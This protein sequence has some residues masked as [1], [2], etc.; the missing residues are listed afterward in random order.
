[1]KRLFYLP[2]PECFPDGNIRGQVYRGLLTVLFLILSLTGCGSGGGGGGGGTTTA[3]L[4]SIAVTPANP[5]VTLGTTGQFTATGTY[6]DSS[7]QNITSSV[8]WSSSDTSKA[9]ISVSG[10]ATTVSVGSTTITA[11]SGS[12][13]GSTTLTISPINPPTITLPK[14]GRTTCYDAAGGVISC[15]NTGQDGDL[16][17]G[18]AWPSPRFTVDGTG[19]CVTDNLTGLMWVRTPD[20]TTRTRAT[21][22]T[23][24]NGLTLCGYTDWR[25]PNVK[26]LRSLINH[27][28]TSTA[29]W[30]NTQGFSN[31]QGDV[32]WSSTG[33]DTTALD[34][35]MWSG[36]V[37]SVVFGTSTSYVWPVRAGGGAT[38]DLP[39]TGQT[40]SYATGDDGNL[41]EGAAWPIPRFTVDGTWLCVTDNLTGLMWVKAPDSTTQTWENAL[42]YANNLTLCGYSDW[43]LPNVNELES[44]RNAE[45]NNTATWL[46]TQGFSNVPA[47]NYW[48]S[49]TYAGSTT[50][51]WRVSMWYGY[52]SGTDKTS[53]FY[54]WPVRAGQ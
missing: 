12:I 46:N 15:T 28:Q 7:T 10:S 24:A 22:L 54:V 14:T 42:N 25:L 43:R 13:S 31:V 52:M 50:S 30:L 23:Y 44:L 33:R 3:T 41:Q 34:V 35:N 21:A 51:A 39:R 29:A 53:T 37:G 1:M 32:Y 45:Q 16:Q 18:A 26:E 19:F 49:T 20:S 48:S 9:I 17:K 40:T 36:D 5:S 47:G 6:S 27:E 2:V 11:T 4:A 8:T 38:A